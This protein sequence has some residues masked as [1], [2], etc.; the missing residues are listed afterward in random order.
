MRVLFAGSGRFAIPSLSAVLASTHEL[1]GVFTQPARPAGRG[2]RLTPTPLA[3]A[4]AEARLDVMECPDINAP[5]AVEQVASLRPDAL[6]VVDFG[7]MVRSALR[8]AA[9]GGA[10]NLHGSLLPELRGAA[11]VN[12]AILRGYAET[13]VTTFELVDRLDAGPIYL[14]EAVELRP[15]ET[16]E[17]LSGRLALLGAPLVVR[18]LDLLDE[19]ATEP[20]LQ[21][22]AR[23]TKAPRLSK[24]GGVIDWTG[25]ATDVRNRI[26]GTWPWPG[27][28]AALVRRQDEPL[29]VTIARA[30]VAEGDAQ[31]EP[32]QVDRDGCV[33]TGEGRVRLLEVKPAGRRLM[34]WRDF[35]NGYR[36]GEGDRF[37]RPEGGAP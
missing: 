12:W 35:V 11:P 31:G 22:D 28:Q 29:R 10:F 4:A 23:A 25:S 15:D 16:A 36:V 5:E 19:G 24:S 33:A 8:K 7:Q 3:A 32:G 30:A 1:V 21:D 14:K 6:C 37:A 20:R 27:G 13:G 26:H 9:P 34:A 17:E 18:T 2:A